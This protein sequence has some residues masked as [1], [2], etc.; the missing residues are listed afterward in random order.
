MLNKKLLWVYIISSICYFVQGFE[1]LPGLSLFLYLKE[2]LGFAP[3]K[4][5]YL[6]AIISLPWLI[7][8]IWGVLIDWLFSHKKWIIISSFVSIV[9]CAFFGLSPVITIPLV[10]I[11]GML[12][13]IGTA[14]RDISA[15]AMMCVKGKEEGE[16]GSIQ[17]LQWTAIT[18]ASIIVGLAGGYIADNFSYKV[19]YLC[20]IPIYI[21]IIAILLK[22]KPNSEVLCNSCIYGKMCSLPLQFNCRQSIRCSIYRLNR[23][24]L[25]TT[26]LSYKE[27]FTNKRFLWV[28][29]FLFLYKYSPGFGTPLTYIQRDTFHWSGQFMGIMGAITSAVS[30]LGSI[31]YF[32]IGKRINIKKWL[33]GSVILGALTT[34]SYLYFTPISA[35]VYDILYAGIGMFIFLIVMAFMAENTIK[36]KEAVSFATLCSVN[37]LAGTCSTASGAYLYPKIGLQPLIIIASLA[38]FLCL[39]VIPKINFTGENNEKTKDCH[40]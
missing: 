16:C 32:K 20:L 30:I 36:G 7:K 5:M 4:I 31:I 38:S 10:I 1:G 9:A 23:S 11:F 6:S 3:E 2:K 29:L 22:Y 35:I 27:L 14:F 17:V 8:P 39:L 25:L 40:S 33:I 37:N 34:L 13:N 12:G 19:A 18:V 21:I 24:K 26:I 15:D 28:C